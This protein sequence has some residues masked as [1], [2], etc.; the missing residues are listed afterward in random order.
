MC[1]AAERSSGSADPG[2]LLRVYRRTGD[3]DARE[4]LVELYLPLVRSLARRYAHCGESLD[5]L[6]QVGSIGLIEAI[7]RFDPERG[8]DLVS[9]AIP[10]ITGEIKRHLRDRSTVVRMPRRL[11]E[12]ALELRSVRELMAARQRRPPTVSELAQEMGVCEADVVEAMETERAR[13]PMWLSTA[14]GE[15]VELDERDSRRRCV[16]YQRGAPAS[17]GRLPHARRARTKD[18]APE[19]LRRVEPGRDCARGGSVPD[20]GVAAHP[21]LPR[22]DESGAR[23]VAAG[24]ARIPHRALVRSVS[25]LY[26]RNMAGAPLLAEDVASSY[27]ISL[28]R[29]GKGRARRGLPR[30]T[31]C[32]APRLEEPRRRRPFVARGPRLRSL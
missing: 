23:A 28:A 8:S 12:L 20:P 18:P 26:T 3:P 6:V 16:R 9:Y 7:D 24:S 25:S 29:D 15:S 21:G 31:S 4:R 17:R 19:L 14:G 2:T 5:D 13:I 22:T 1:L 30:S 27:R 32:R 10:T 11:V